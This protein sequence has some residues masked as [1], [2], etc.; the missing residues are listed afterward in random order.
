MFNLM[1]VCRSL[2]LLARDISSLSH[3]SLYKAA[4]NMA[5]YIPQ[6]KHSRAERE[7]GREG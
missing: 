7:G 5:P 4:H 3:G 6:S 2:W 1:P